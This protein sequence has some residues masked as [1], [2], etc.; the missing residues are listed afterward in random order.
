MK[1]P[2]MRGLDFQGPALVGGALTYL[3]GA[4]YV[5]RVVAL[6]FL[7]YAGQISAAQID[8][9][10]K[11]FHEVDAALVIVA[12]GVCPL[13]RL[14]IGQGNRP[15]TPVL[16]DP[17][18]RLHR[19]FGVP[20]AEPSERCHTFVIDRTGILRLRVSHDFVEHD[21]TVLREVVG[22]SQPLAATRLERNET[23][24]EARG[25]CRPM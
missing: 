19:S 17:C 22:L 25:A 8:R 6:C 9:H 13:H 4:R 10:A 7:P 1:Q 24:A 12:S 20:V 23:P 14:W 11:R 15:L 21:L 18:G 5:D 3:H 2:G 16:A